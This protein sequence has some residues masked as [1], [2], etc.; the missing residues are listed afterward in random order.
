ML[1]IRRVLASHFAPD[2]SNTSLKLPYLVARQAQFGPEYSTPKGQGT[3]AI[4]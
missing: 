4:G 2:E 3:S 1:Q